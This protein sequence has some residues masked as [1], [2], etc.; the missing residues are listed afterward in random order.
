MLSIKDIARSGHV[1][2]WHSVR[3]S[4]NQNLAEHQYMV[5]MLAQEMALR[6]FNA[7][8]S[9]SDYRALTEYAL[10]HDTP[11]IVLGDIPGPVKRK[12]EL[13]YDEESPFDELEASVCSRF[14][15]AKERVQNSA[16]MVIV[17]LADLADAI[18][19]ITEEGN[20]KQAYKI[21]EQTRQYFY[22]CITEA[23]EFYSDLNWDGASYVLE[24]ALNGED[25]QLTH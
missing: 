1:T 13:I 19:F 10:R 2:R 23:S 25:M 18:V 11:E 15:A 4:R 22:R 20:S 21:S 8:L 9:D 24:E 12:L 7:P 5:A 14:K 16:L 3:T 17:Q 6:I